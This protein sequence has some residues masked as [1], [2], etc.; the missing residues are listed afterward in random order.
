M[1]AIIR[2]TLVCHTAK[3]MLAVWSCFIIKKKKKNLNMLSDFPFLFLSRFQNI[4]AMG[5]LD[6]TFLISDTT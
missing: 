5:W 3:I 6:T 1:V 2:H 4:L